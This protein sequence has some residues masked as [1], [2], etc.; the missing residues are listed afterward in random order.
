[1]DV[2]RT[3]DERFE[4]LPEFPF[5]PRYVELEGLRLAR[6]DEGEGEPVLFLHGEP[7]WSYLWRRVI[8]PQ[9]RKARFI[10]R[11]VPPRRGARSRRW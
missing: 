10:G 5:E 2:F 1:M 7:T 6:V 3:P 9:P 11:P 8:P 4:S